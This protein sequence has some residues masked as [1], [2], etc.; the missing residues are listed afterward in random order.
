MVEHS[1]SDTTIYG[2]DISNE[3]AHLSIERIA[4]E[5]TQ[6]ALEAVQTANAKLIAAAPELL[7][8]LKQAKAWLE[9]WGSAENELAIINAALA[10]AE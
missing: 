6:A 2:G 10:K 7:D 5:K 9:G 4:T 1:W 8:A 3:I